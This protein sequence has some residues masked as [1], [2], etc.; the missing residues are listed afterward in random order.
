VSALD[1]R[2]YTAHGDAWQAQ[3]RLRAARGGGAADL[4]GVR[5]MASGL[6]FAQWNNGDVTDAARFRV[7]DVRAWYAERAHGRGVPWGV[8][9]PAAT[10]FAHGR[11][12]FRK[13]CM[14]LSP[15]RFVTAECPIGVDIRAAGTADVD[16]VAAIDAAAFG[17]S[18]EWTR[19]WVEPYLGAPGFSVALA[20]LHGTAVGIAT[21]ILT[22]DRAGRCAGIF[23]VGVLEGARRRGIASAMTSWLLEGAFA[24]GARLAHL[25]PDSDHAAKL[26]AQLGFVECA[27][28]DIY[29]DL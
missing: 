2:V 27:G 8:R 9:V 24:E 20:T 12:L 3:G 6:P 10:P 29:T 18:L 26:Y 17:E 22:N 5:L 16:T 1:Q 15:D 19:Q 7:E 21:A 14:G 4:P 28:L 23:G 13:R 25:N 11:R